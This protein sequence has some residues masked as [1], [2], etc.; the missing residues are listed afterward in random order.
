MPDAELKA[1][2]VWEVLRECPDVGDA[3]RRAKEWVQRETLRGT[4]MGAWYGGG[5]LSGTFST[6]AFPSAPSL[7][8]TGNPSL[9]IGPGAGASLN[10]SAGYTYYAAWPWSHN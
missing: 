6:P 2:L 10:L 8:Y 3:V 1:A 9:T 4:V 5:A 7:N